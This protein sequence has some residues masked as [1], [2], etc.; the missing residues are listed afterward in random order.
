MHRRAMSLRQ[1][2]AVSM[3]SNLLLM[4]ILLTMVALG[5][6]RSVNAS[7][8]EH[9]V[10]QAAMV[11]MLDA[12]FHVVQVQQ[13]LTDVGATGER[14]GF[15]EAETEFQGANAM[16]KEI[17]RLLPNVGDEVAKIGEALEVFY[18]VG[19]KM[20]EAYVVAGQQAG[21]Q[22][23]KQPETGF[24]ARAEI[25]TKRIAVLEKNLRGMMQEEALETEQSIARA[26]LV[27]L[28]MGGCVMLLGI[29]TSVLM[30]K[31][32]LR[33]LGGE[34]T[35]AKAVVESIAGGDL[36]QPIELRHGDTSSL[37]AFQQ[38]MQSGLRSMVSEITASVRSTEQSASALTDASRHVAEASNATSE[39]AAAM[40][41]G[42]QEMSVSIG[43]VSSDAQQALDISDRAGHLAVSG[44]EVIESAI[45]TISQIAETVRLTAADL[46]SLSKDSEKVTAVVQAIRELA[47]QTNLLAL[48][49]AI[50]AARAGEQ[51]RGFAV[52][53]DEVRK[54]AERTA[55]AT[56][57]ITETIGI[58]Q[59]HT[60]LSVATM[61]KAVAEVDRG[62]DYAEKAGIALSDIRAGVLEVVRVVNGIVG[63]IQEQSAASQ[64]IAE[65]VESVAQASDVNTAAAHQMADSAKVLDSLAGSLSSAIQRFKT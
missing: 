29:T 54:L 59:A 47:D 63:A 6:N 41:S 11:A 62:V 27:A 50:E 14:G 45:L 32:L 61:E 33:M 37:M 25:L 22:L 23:M 8:H 12:R 26:R 56:T 3:I 31:M 13:F 35:V 18:G 1:I 40:A 65:R 19:K 52:V 55:S 24:D 10:T 39:A 28:V 5:F 30:Y 44:G 64:Q 38:Q 2:I 49:A 9:Q 36:T 21:N 15:G 46:V 57:E 34:P 7:R 20:A 17:Q 51:G 4:V 58:V 16:L 43:Q 42:M 60:L 53:A 48:N